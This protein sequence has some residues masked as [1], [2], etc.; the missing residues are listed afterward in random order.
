ME[1]PGGYEQN[2]TNKLNKEQKPHY[3]LIIAI[4]A[5]GRI[6]QNMLTPTIRSQ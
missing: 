1:I 6:G 5:G 4:R 2:S 3:I